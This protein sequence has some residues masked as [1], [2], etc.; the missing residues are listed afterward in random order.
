MGCDLHS[1]KK[2]RRSPFLYVLDGCEEEKSRDQ[3]QI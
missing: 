2:S 3:V 1:I